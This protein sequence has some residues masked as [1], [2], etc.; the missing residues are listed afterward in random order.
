MYRADCMELMKS[1]K[2][3]DLAII[4][5]PYGLGEKISQGGNEKS[6]STVNFHNVYNKS[7]AWDKAPD[8]YYFQ[9]L[10]NSTKNQIICGGNYFPEIWTKPVRGIIWWD[11]HTPVDNF[12]AGELLWTS[13]SKPARKFD[14]MYT[15]II[16]GN[17]HRLKVNHPTSKPISLYKWLLKNYAPKCKYC[18]GNGSYYEDVAGDGG[19]RMMMH[20]DECNGTGNGT[21]LDTH[22]GSMSIA[23]A[24]WYLGFDLDI[25]ELDKGY[26]DAAVKRFEN[27]ISQ[28]VL[29]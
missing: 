29:F 3:W 5:P 7:S 8:K 15:N 28:Q 16:D 9:A 27:H 22:G 1:G 4:D 2:K 13:F 26:F 25:C 20:C 19:S 17:S 21:I 12:S 14:H 6:K 11:K 18:K 10:F 23:I 24:C